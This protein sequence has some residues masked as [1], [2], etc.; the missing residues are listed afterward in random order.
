VLDH[1]AA[2]EAFRARLLTLVVATT[3]TTNLSAT[4]TGY[5]RPAGSFPTDEFSPGMEVVGIGFA[6]APLAGNNAPAIIQDVVLG[7]PLVMKILGGRTTEAGASGRR[8]TVGL[9]Q[10]RRWAGTQTPVSTAPATRPNIV[11]QWVPGG[12]EDDGAIIDTGQY[13]ITWNGLANYGAAAMLRQMTALRDHF[14]PGLSFTINSD[15]VRITGKPAPSFTQP[16]TLANGIET[17]TIRIP[18]RVA[19]TNLDPV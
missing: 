5:A 19:T 13:V 3:G 4:T 11:E 7:T 14:P 2:R 18:W 16:T 8:L 17:S 10:E 1:L 15:I 12:I 9:P 6:G